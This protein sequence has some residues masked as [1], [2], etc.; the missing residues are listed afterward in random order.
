MVLPGFAPMD[1]FA[2]A[3]S[4]ALSL[5]EPEVAQM[6]Y[7]LSLSVHLQRL[8]KPQPSVSRPPM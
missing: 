4:A 1:A 5:G 6:Q 7:I 2:L 3:R 8:A